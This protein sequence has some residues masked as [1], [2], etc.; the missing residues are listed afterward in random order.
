M[1]SHQ[2]S[3]TVNRCVWAY[4]LEEQSCQISFRSDLKRRNVRIFWRCSPNNNKI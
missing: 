1:T 2:K 3:E 4:I